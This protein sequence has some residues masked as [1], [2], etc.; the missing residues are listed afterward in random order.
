V[1]LE[2]NWGG[3]VAIVG[4]YESPRRK[5]PG[6]HPF[7]IQAECVL[8]ALDDAGL[9][10]A[11]VDGL[12][13]SANSPGEGAGWMDICEVAEYLG[14]EP[15]FADGTDTGGAAPIAQA[16]HAA[17]AIAAG[18]A[19]VVVVSYAGCSYSGGGDFDT[20]PSTWGPWAYEAPYGFT[21]VASYAL[22]AQRHM[23]EFGTT[24]EQ[25]AAI[26]VRCR[27]NAGP[28]EHARYRDPMTVDDVL[29][30]PM[31][32]SPLH[33]NDCCVVTD[34]GGAVVL[35][36]RDRAAD[37]P[38]RP[39]WLLGFGE[40]VGKMRTSQMPSFT[41]TP[42]AV[43]G[44]RAF[45]MAGLRPDEMHCAQLYDSFTITALLALEDLG[46]CKKGEGG[47]FV[48]SGEIGPDG[49]IPINTDGGGLSSN[50][51]GRRGA[52]AL[53]EAV[54]QLR[55]EGPGV[56]LPDPTLA[57]AHGVGGQLTATATMVLGV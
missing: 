37:A 5:A 51:P 34:S 9:S 10:L 2:S 13:T 42:G 49:S 19:D 57:V 46:F 12:C 8:A 52:F 53:I 20:L 39:A 31:I 7:Q 38:K 24:A 54:R 36:G 17:T 30:S 29:A 43:S 27:S 3:Q 21:T 41:E 16:G 33:R 14:I 26:A 28:N 48:E 6:V 45:D 25:L 15:T 44:A 56:Q 40:A 18:L 47:P 23:H 55:G 22:A 11:E 35:V 50:H 32:A 1:E 4:A